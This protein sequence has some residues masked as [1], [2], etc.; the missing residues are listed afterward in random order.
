MMNSHDLQE[1]K[2]VKMAQQGDTEAFAGIVEKYLPRIFS[3]CLKLTGNHEDAEDCVQECFVKAWVSMGEFGERSS[4]YT[5]LY[6]IAVNTCFDFNRSKS[7]NRTSSLDNCLNHDSDGS[8]AVELLQDQEP[9]PD[10]VV[11][12]HESAEHVRTLLLELPDNMR[13][14]L[15]LR[16]LQGYNYREIAQ[17]LDIAEGTVKSRLFRARKQMMDLIEKPEQI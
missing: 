6:R 14:V 10:E 16:D 13:D 17:Y 1:H 12:H 11:E 5:W 3:I 9:L 8:S 7:R 15:I 4:I 2:N